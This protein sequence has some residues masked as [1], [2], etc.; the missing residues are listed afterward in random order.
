MATPADVVR[1]AVALLNEAHET[2]A[3][4]ERERAHRR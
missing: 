3:E 1:T 2:A 4:Q